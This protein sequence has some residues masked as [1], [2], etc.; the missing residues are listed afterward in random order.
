MPVD[1]L[2]RLAP[3]PHE[4]RSSR[5][6]LIAITA[7]KDHLLICLDFEGVART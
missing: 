2:N 6:I 3:Q 7:K 5:L 4:W 1:A